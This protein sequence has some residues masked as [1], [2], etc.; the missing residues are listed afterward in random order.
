MIETERKPERLYVST[1]SEIA[2]TERNTTRP[3]P[4]EP[5]GNIEKSLCT[6][7]RYQLE[8]LV[9]NPNG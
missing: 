7:R 9:A 5:V 8:F 1:T 6:V 3:T 4:A 2:T